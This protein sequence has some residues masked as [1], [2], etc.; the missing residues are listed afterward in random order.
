MR[1]LAVA[2]LAAQVGL[3]LAWLPASAADAPIDG[4]WVATC[5]E[6]SLSGFI[7]HAK[8]RDPSGNLRDATL[9]ILTCAQ[10]ATATNVNGKIPAGLT[11]TQ[12]TF[13]RHRWEPTDDAGG[14]IILF[15]AGA[16]NNQTVEVP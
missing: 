5:P 14:C 4:S 2:F 12:A 1:A 9:D 7:L 10:P 16:P 6:A 8:C 15:I 3:S 11:K 13:D